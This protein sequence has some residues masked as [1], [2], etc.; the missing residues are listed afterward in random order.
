MFLCFV[1]V[2]FVEEIDEEKLKESKSLVGFETFVQYP[3]EQ[4]PDF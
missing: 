2:N 4:S 3:A 1:L